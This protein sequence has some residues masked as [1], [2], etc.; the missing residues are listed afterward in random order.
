MSS[1]LP[2]LPLWTTSANR[3]EEED[4]FAVD[5]P[6]A[7][8]ESGLWI[9]PVEGTI[10]AAWNPGIDHWGVDIVA[11]EN[12]PVKAVGEGTVV[13]AGFTAGGEATPS[14]CNTNATAFPSTCTTAGLEVASGDRVRQGEMIAVIGNRATTVPA[15]TSTL[16]GGNP[17]RPLIRSCGFRLQD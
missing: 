14:S 13:F 12:S 15:L 7:L 6:N 4:A 11:P 17:E 5:R 9:P 8:D 16:S 1:K 2:L 10:S 3:V